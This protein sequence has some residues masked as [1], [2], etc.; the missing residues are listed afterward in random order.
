MVE[1]RFHM[2]SVFLGSYVALAVWAIRISDYFW[3][4]VLSV[5]MVALPFLFHGALQIRA[6]VGKLPDGT[7]GMTPHPEQLEDFLCETLLKSR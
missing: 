2:A 1:L 4:G 3:L 7:R 5:F 6:H